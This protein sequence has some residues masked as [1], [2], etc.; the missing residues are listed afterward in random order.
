MTVGSGIATSG[1]RPA[2]S[3]RRPTSRFCA[4]RWST[5]SV[6][7]PLRQ[8]RAMLDDAESILVDPATVALL[9]RE[10][11]ASPTILWLCGPPRCWSWRYS[12]LGNLC[13][14]RAS[15]RW[16][17]QQPLRICSI[18]RHA[19]SGLVSGFCGSRSSPEPPRSASETSEALMYEACA[20]AM[21]DSSQRAASILRQAV[22]VSDAPAQDWIV[23]LSELAARQPAISA[24]IPALVD[25][26]PTTKS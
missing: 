22:A 24:L 14:T 5:A 20:L 25:E 9:S 8:Q 6:T 17:N 18:R 26:L 3:G 12:I 4:L 16:N 2:R 11:T 7:H 21:I 15:T 1:Y 19:A 13:W 10:A 23:R